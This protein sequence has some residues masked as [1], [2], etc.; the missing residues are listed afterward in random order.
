MKAHG[1]GLT[2]PSG[3]SLPLSSAVE[4][5]GLVFFSGQIALKDGQIRGDI[6]DQTNLVFDILE[7]KLAALDLSLENVA[8]ATIWLTEASDFARFN[9]VYRKRM[10]APYPARSCVLSTLML[11]GA[12]IELEIVAGRTRRSV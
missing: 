1:V 5:D 3:E 10:S 2:T 4:L 8:K 9:S 12:L 6:E 7:A 11:S